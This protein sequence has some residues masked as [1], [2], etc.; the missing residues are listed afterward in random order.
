MSDKRQE[1][2]NTIFMLGRDLVSGIN[3]EYAIA[4]ALASAAEDRK[5]LARN[6]LQPYLQPCCDKLGVHVIVDSPHVKLVANVVRGSR[7]LNENL[8]LANIMQR[9]NID[10]RTA[11]EII[12]SSKVEGNNQVRLTVARLAAD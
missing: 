7:R 8:L 2:K 11:R 4:C 6:S 5:D 12:E 10:Y 9:C 1:L 3:D